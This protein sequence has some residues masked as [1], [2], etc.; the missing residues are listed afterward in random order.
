MAAI[1]ATADIPSKQQTETKQL[2]YTV[3][4]GFSHG[5][6]T[7]TTLLWTSE[8]HGDDTCSEEAGD[9]LDD[10]NDVGRRGGRGVAVVGV[11]SRNSG[12]KSRV[13]SVQTICR[14]TSSVG[15]LA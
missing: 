9:W 5:G 13:A 12:G 8:E 7:F 10:V 3:C 15:S 11:A 6:S 14:L 2:H 4:D 1:A